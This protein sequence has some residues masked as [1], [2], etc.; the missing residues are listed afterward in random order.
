M[1]I[2]RLKVIRSTL[3]KGYFNTEDW[4]FYPS[5]CDATFYHEGPANLRVASDWMKGREGWDHE[6]VTVEISEV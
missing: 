4:A 6:I 5:I 1:P 3:G 2:A